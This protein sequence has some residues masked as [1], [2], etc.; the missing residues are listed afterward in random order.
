MNFVYKAL[1]QNEN[2]V[3][4]EMVVNATYKICYCYIPPPVNKLKILDQDRTVAVED[5]GLG[6][7]GDKELK[8]DIKMI[9]SPYIHFQGDTAFSHSIHHATKRI[10]KRVHI[11]Q[12]SVVGAL[13]PAMCLPLYG[14]V[15]VNVA[16]TREQS[17]IY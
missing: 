12:P 3:V 6:E 4:V 10:L 9:S 1:K 13:F 2:N 17:V 14:E 5:V 11:S 16:L 15:M 8:N 7:E